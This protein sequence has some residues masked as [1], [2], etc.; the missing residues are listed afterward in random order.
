MMPHP[1][2]PRSLSRTAACVCLALAIATACGGGSSNRHTFEVRSGTGTVSGA[3][4]LTVVGIWAAYFESEGLTGGGTDLNGDMDT[5]DEVV[6]AIHIEDATDTSLGVAAIAVAIVGDHF[7]LQVEESADTK[8]WNGINGMT[9]R[10]LL[11]WTSSTSVVTFVDTLN[12]SPR[13][14]GVVALADRLFYSA[15]VAALAGDET[16]LRRI[17]TDGPTTPVAIS[18]QL[19]GGTLDAVVL[20]EEDGLVFLLAD[21]ADV[22]RDLNGDPAPFDDLVLALIDGTQTAVPVVNVGLAI[23]DE[24]APFGA[25]IDFDGDWLVAFLVDEAAQGATNLNAPGLFVNK[26]VPDACDGTPDVDTLDQV[27]HYLRFDDFVLGGM[28]VNTGLVGRD[29]VLVVA[30][31]VATLS[32]EMAANC[33]LNGDVD[34]AD[35]V[36]RWVTTTTPVAPPRDPSQLFAVDTLIPG[37]AMGVA[38]LFDRI[39]C[40]VD[41]AQDSRNQDGKPED[42]DLVAWLDPATG[43]TAAW[44]FAHQSSKSAGVG[45]GIFEDVDGDGVGDPKS[46]ASE[47]FAGTGWM[48]ADDS[49]GRLA[50]TFL[51]AVPGTNPMVGSLNLNLDCAVFFKDADKTDS[52]PVWLDFAQTDVLDFDGVGFAVDAA[53]AG[54]VIAGFNVFF[55]VHEADDG[56]DHNEDGAVDDVVLMRNS[57]NRCDPVAMAT[58]SIIPGP[59]VVTDGT[60]G[61]AFFADESLTGEDYNENGFAFDIVVRYFTF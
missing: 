16:S 21:E 20:G 51:E 1:I 25:A 37:G 6:R 12:P 55:R 5:M 42:H 26:L 34:T 45:T 8:D 49:F 57:V 13:G 43:A 31:A 17:E 36:V 60:L 19:G 44:T 54:I 10:V 41:E 59:V 33:S 14:P 52:L 7:Y 29:R 22:A 24:D 28:A 47:P 58:S 27:L 9:D 3:T 53:N 38:T 15:D 40:V 50:L 61:A 11:H 18:N 4:E 39:V 23:R 35:T 32:D 48:S 2:R 56:I 46:G 30:D